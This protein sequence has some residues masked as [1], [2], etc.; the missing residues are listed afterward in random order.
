M[1]LRRR[2][3][4]VLQVADVEFLPRDLLGLRCALSP[5]I[6]V[7]RSNSEIRRLQKN[8]GEIEIV[9]QEYA[10]TRRYSAR[11]RGCC[12]TRGG[13][14][15]QRTGLSKASR[16]KE[17]V[18]GRLAL[19]GLPEF[20]KLFAQRLVVLALGLELVFLVQDRVHEHENLFLEREARLVLVALDRRRELIEAQV[21][22]VDAQDLPVHLLV[23]A[24]VLLLRLLQS[25]LEDAD[26]IILEL[27]PPQLQEEPLLVLSEL[28]VL[29]TQL[30]DEVLAF[31]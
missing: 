31:L 17:P 15:I 18:T 13:P 29:E 27:G 12:N 30:V 7:L 23:H 10:D 24:L 6:E 22:L 4:L 14:S 16:K 1:P 25:F 26:E 21:N 3:L 19:P 28:L 8:E 9:S 5:A 11:R 2:E 20:C